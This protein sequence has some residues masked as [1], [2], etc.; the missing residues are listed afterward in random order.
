MI[1]KHLISYED[2]KQFL[3]GK[4]EI[5]IIYKMS[6]KYPA[7]GLF[8]TIQKLGSPL[9]N[10]SENREFT[11][12]DAESFL[13]D[14]MAGTLNVKGATDILNSIIASEQNFEKLIYKIN[15]NIKAVEE[16][17]LYNKV[18]V[19]QKDDAQIIE[20]FSKLK[21]PQIFSSPFVSRYPK[22]VYTILAAAAI[23]LVLFFVPFSIQKELADHYNFDETVPL[24]YLNSEMRSERA[25]QDY[26][27][28]EL[29]NENIFK[30]GM[31]DYLAHDY[32]SAIRE[33]QSLEEKLQQEKK[34]SFDARFEE[35]FYL[36]YALGHLALALSP[37]EE[38]TDAEKEKLYSYSLLLFDNVSI[39]NDFEYY[40][41]ALML[42]LNKREAEALQ[43]LI[44]IDRSS[45]FYAKKVILEEQLFQ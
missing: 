29:D 42:A 24:D 34:T 3:I 17:S 8:I 12:D 41:Y 21:I 4:K 19:P 13:Q 18:F 26:S 35:Q 32:R 43:N 5:D 36:Y 15:E 30:Q 38:I 27:M 10:Y 16:T 44:Q 31:A 37:K 45:A 20:G 33:W 22:T 11:F 23:F 14:Y 39:N 9:I 28:Q 7:Y 2:I 6:E 25:V 40:Y 1:N